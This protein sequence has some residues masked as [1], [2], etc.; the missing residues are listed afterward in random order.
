MRGRETGV[1]PGAKFEWDEGVHRGAKGEDRKQAKQTLSR[2]RRVEGVISMVR[3]CVSVLSQA[4]RE[5]PGVSCSSSTS[6]GARG[7]AACVLCHG[8]GQTAKRNARPEDSKRKRKR[9]HRGISKHMR[10]KLLSD[11]KAT[12]TKERRER[13]CGSVKA[14]P[15]GVSKSVFREYQGRE[16][17][18]TLPR[19]FRIHTAKG[20]MYGEGFYR[21]GPALSIHM[22]LLS[23]HISTS[24][25]FRTLEKWKNDHAILPRCSS[26]LVIL[27]FMG[28]LYPCAR[29]RST[30]WGIATSLQFAPYMQVWNIAP[31]IS[32]HNQLGSLLGHRSIFQYGSVPGNSAFE[33]LNIPRSELLPGWCSSSTQVDNLE[34]VL[35]RA[36]DDKEQRHNNVRTARACGIATWLNQTLETQRG[37]VLPSLSWSLPGY[38]ACCSVACRR[39]CANIRFTGTARETHSGVALPRNRE[40]VAF[41]FAQENGLQRGIPAKRSSAALDR[42]LATMRSGLRGRQGLYSAPWRRTCTLRLGAVLTGLAMN[43]LEL[44]MRFTSIVCFLATITAAYAGTIE[45]RQGC[46]GTKVCPT[47]TVLICCKGINLD[48]T[49][50][51]SMAT[52]WPACK[53]LSWHYSVYTHAQ[54]PGLVEEGKGSEDN[55]KRGKSKLSMEEIQGTSII[56]RKWNESHG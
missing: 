51:F 37:E 36:G 10:P 55:E 29:V 56:E 47:N 32:A 11:A 53:T 28:I 39:A 50:A 3:I 33:T 9:A 2:P 8:A 14:C 7:L 26:T 16:H 25:G 40:Q 44:N 46:P 54:S 41:E 34:N 1:E 42:G 15:Q 12:R 4:R 17:P 19:G 5:R 43:V 21:H 35:P 49:C 13:L 31:R 18:R 38:L 52:D 6:S 27:Q 23:L 22:S 30:V 20:T 45:M 48:S 24:L